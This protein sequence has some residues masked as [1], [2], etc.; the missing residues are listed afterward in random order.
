MEEDLKCLFSRIIENNKQ[1]ILRIC[2]AYS[3]NKEDQKDLFQEV[4][5]KYLEVFTLFS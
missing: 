2:W 3:N 1:M 4:A 5:F